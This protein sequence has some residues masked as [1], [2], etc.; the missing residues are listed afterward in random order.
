MGR[1]KQHSTE[2]RDLQKRVQAVRLARVMRHMLATLDEPFDL[3]RLAGVAAISRYHFVRQFKALTGH[4]PER[5]HLRLR[6]QRAAWA[7]VCEG[8]R[9][10]DVALAAGFDSADGFSRAFQR[11]YRISPSAFRRLGADPWAGFSPFGHWR[12]DTFDKHPRKTGVTNMELRQLP[13]MVYAGVRSVGPY[14]TVGPA[15]QRIIGWAAGAGL[16][17]QDTRVL[18]LSWD[19]SATVPADRLRYDAAIT[20]DRPVDTPDDIRLAA[21]PAMTWAMVTHEGSYA[22]MPESFRQVATAVDA[23][24][25][26]VY[27]PLCA[28][29]M[30]LNDAGNTPEADLRTDIGF[31]V[32]KVIGGG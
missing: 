24:R 26:L 28:L 20:L 22:T 5:F 30:Y 19:D 9:V 16:M 14:N 6:L 2:S 27:A 13:A 1:S 29:E 31:P 21:L 10:V 7:L 11:M 4:A 12:P 15:F 25:S 32:V 8:D 17:K 23:D 3:D 18:G